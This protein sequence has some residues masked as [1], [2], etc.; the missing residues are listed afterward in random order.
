[1]LQKSQY[2]HPVPGF[3]LLGEIFFLLDNEYLVQM[4]WNPLKCR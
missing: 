2:A 4:I 1:M 3:H